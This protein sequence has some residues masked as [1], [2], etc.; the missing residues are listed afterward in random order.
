MSKI[1]EIAS[2]KTG[3]PVSKNNGKANSENFN[4]DI[5][6]SNSEPAAENIG[7]PY[8][9]NF[10]DDINKKI[11][12]GIVTYERKEFFT[13]LLDSL[14][15][16][17]ELVVVNDGKPYPDTIFKNRNLKLIQH[18]R[19]KGVGRSKND[20]MK[21]LLQMGCEHI[22]VLEDDIYIKDNS[23]FEDYITASKKTGLQHFNFAWH[24]PLNKDENGNPKPR[25]VAKYNDEP[26]L[27]L[28]EHIPGAFSYFSS[29]ILKETGFIDPIYYNAWEHVDLTTRIAKKEAYTPFWWFADVYGSDKKIVD[30]D[31][32]L[33]E[34]S[35]RKNNFKFMLFFRIF[36]RY[37]RL[38]HGYIPYKTPDCGLDAVKESLINI[39]KKHNPESSTPSIEV[40]LF[41]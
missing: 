25:G 16:N 39:F 14:P 19:N 15:E 2:G 37:Y 32:D 20:A 28:N 9:K 5:N 30:Q 17:I 24:G 22:F 29:D 38:K 13:R 18:K 11:G 1:G 41:G 6:K 7:K 21:Y 4:D 12:V 40:E 26:L 3:K 10:N 31:T 36:S 23:V 27:T 8:G 34:S 33:K 35:I